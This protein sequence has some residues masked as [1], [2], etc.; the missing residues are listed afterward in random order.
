MCTEGKRRSFP[1]ERRRSRRIR[2]APRIARRCPG[3]TNERH[4]FRLRVSEEGSGSRARSSRAER[5]IRHCAS[6]ALAS[7][8][9]CECE[10]RQ[11]RARRA[12]PGRRA[13]VLDE[14]AKRVRKA[15]AHE[16]QPLRAERAI[17]T[18]GAEAFFPLRATT[19]S[20][21]QRRAQDRAPLS[22]TNEGAD[23]P[24]VCE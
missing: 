20:P 2:S 9:A 4:A 16:R 21:D 1:C 7:R 12:E 15:A 11:S 14:R 13:A 18:E 6:K 22:W 8:P 19:K 3:R 10:R 17:Y 24:F 5:A 23:T